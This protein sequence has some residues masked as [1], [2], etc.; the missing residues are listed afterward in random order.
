PEKA[1]EST[2][3]R[4]NHLAKRQRTWWRTQARVEWVGGPKDA[5]DV[6]RAAAEVAAIWEKHGKTPVALP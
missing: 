6:P 5:S 3:T 2:I 4:T 1:L